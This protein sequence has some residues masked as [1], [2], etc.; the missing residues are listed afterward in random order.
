M[1]V[2]S[3]QNQDL[4]PLPALRWNTAAGQKLAV[5]SASV[6]S[7][8]IAA[9]VVCLCSTVAC[10]Y[11]VGLNP[12][13][14]AGGAGCLLPAN[15]VEVIAIEPGDIVAV[16]QDSAGGFLSVVPAAQA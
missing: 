15:T 8:V 3:A 1:P 5:G 4:Q 7:A 9:G 14:S 13:A 16:I 10:W 2:Q 6:A 12:T 11:A